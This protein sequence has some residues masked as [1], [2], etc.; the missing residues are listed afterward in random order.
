MAWVTEKMRVFTG[1]IGADARAVAGG[2]VAMRKSGARS[3]CAPVLALALLGVFGL[4]Q[5]Q[6]ASLYKWVDADGNV[7]Y[8]GVPPTDVE[9]EA[10]EYTEP[11]ERELEENTLATEAAAREN[12]VSLYTVPSCS[13]CDLVRL[14]LEKNAVP[15][16]EKNVQSRIALQEELEQ[17]TGQLSVPTLMI[18]DLF[19]DGYSRIAIRRAL[20]ERG[21]PL[22]GDRPESLETVAP[23]APPALPDT[24]TN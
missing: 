7:T 4:L 16:V 19:L 22:V 3:A 13:A 20:Q 14:Y 9:Y 11:G 10:R 12:P 23:D 6:A 18:G 1:R 15:F 21:F 2:A 17:K 8:Q 24:G 5:A